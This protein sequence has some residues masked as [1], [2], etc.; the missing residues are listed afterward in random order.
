MEI[1]IKT[2]IEKHLPSQVGD[3]LKKT[4]EQAE[5]DAIKV[6]QQ[7]QSLINK[8]HTITELEKEIAKYQKFDERNATLEARE[9]TVSDGERNLKIST[10]EFQIQCEREKAEFS[11]QV[12]LGLVRNTEYRKNIFDNQNTPYTDKYGNTNYSNVTKN[13]DETNK[14]E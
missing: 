4:L 3:V 11:K 7:E 1:E 8:N 10:L 12:A 14:A 9:K 6:N 5:K 2:I 13:L